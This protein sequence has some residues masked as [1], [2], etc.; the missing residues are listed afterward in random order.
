MYLQSSKCIILK[1]SYSLQL[2]FVINSSNNNSSITTISSFLLLTRQCHDSVFCLSN[3]YPEAE[4][5]MSS[6]KKKL[7]IALS[8]RLS[9]LSGIEFL[10]NTS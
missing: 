2:L 9:E 3:L 5:E 1:V 7:R 10:S 6:V 8:K 4:T